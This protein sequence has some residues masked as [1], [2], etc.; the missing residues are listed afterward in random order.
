MKIFVLDDMPGRHM[1]IKR[2]LVLNLG[3]HFEYIEATDVESAKERLNE[4]ESFDMLLLD[5]DLGERTFVES[6]DPNTGYQVAKYIVEQ[7]IKYEIAIV[8]S[9]N[10][11]GAANIVQ[12]LPRSEHIPIHMLVQAAINNPYPIISAH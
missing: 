7:G 10:V 2:W 11:W 3:P 6:S 1:I 5:H 12:I 8:H 9:Q 4:H